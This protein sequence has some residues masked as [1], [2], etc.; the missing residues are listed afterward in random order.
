LFETDRAEI[1]RGAVPLFEML[2]VLL[3]FWPTTTVAKFS[4]LADSVRPGT[5]FCV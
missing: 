3:T 4:A 1:R 2:K 5:A